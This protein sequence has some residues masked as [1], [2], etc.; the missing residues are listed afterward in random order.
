MKKSNLTAPQIKFF[1]FIFAAQ[2]HSGAKKPVSLETALDMIEEAGFS[3]VGVWPDPAV[4]A[5]T[6][7]RG[8]HR[9][10]YIDANDKTWRESLEKA[11]SMKAHRVNVQLWDHDTPPAVAV[12]T[13]IK[14]EKLA[15]QMGLNV[16]LE[17]HR[18]TC[19]ET[20]EKTYE[21]QGL[22]RKATGR[23]I[24]FCWDFSHFG[25]VKHLAAPFAPRLLTHPR[26]VQQARQIHC[27]SFNGH[28]CQVPIL[29]AKG[30]LAPDCRDFL[31]FVDALLACWFEGAKGGEVLYLNPEQLPGPGYGLSNFQNLW[32]EIVVLRRE[33]QVLWDK[34]QK[35]WQKKHR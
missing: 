8:I 12:K 9:V 18:D 31:E 33:I 22:Y 14:L 29:D 4:L 25:V 34:N 23:D 30:R 24:R 32:K 11:A 26:L 1:T 3:A 28:H 20:P 7:K 17:T 6:E 19:T 27:R 2:N 15:G 10:S 21:I 5:A 16:D 13:W 35:I